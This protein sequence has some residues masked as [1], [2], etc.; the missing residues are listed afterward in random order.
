MV[1]LKLMLVLA[2]I[3]QGFTTFAQSEENTSSTTVTNDEVSE[4][5]EETPSPSGVEK[6]EVTGSHI[7]RTDVE[8]PSPVLVIDRQQIEASGFNSVSTILQRSTVSP[9]G[10][11]G[12]SVNLKGIG[13]G[14]TLI[15]INGQRAP[16]S[17]SSYASGAVSVDLVPL[18]A[19]E[20]IEVLKDGASATYGSDALG[21]VVN[22]ITRKN[23]DGFTFAN[24]YNM[25]T[26]IGTDM[27]RLSG[28]YG[29]QTSK[30]NF[31]TSM[32]MTWSQG[33]R[34]S[35]LDFARDL[36]KSFPFSTNYLDDSSA[37]RPGP[38]CNQLNSQGRCEEVVS[39]NQITEDGYGVDWVTQYSYEISSD[40][41]V[42]TSL[43][44][45]YGYGKSSFPNLLNTPGQF[46]GFDLTAA[47][48][49][50]AWNTL[51]GYTGGDTRIWHRFDDYVNTSIDQSYYAGLVTGVKG[52]LGNTDWQWDVSLNNQFNVATTK[53]QQL[54][55][56]GGA[57]D[58]IIGG[59]Y[60]PF[61]L[62]VRDTTGLGID[63]FNRNRAQISWL[64]AKTNGQLGSFLGIDW[65]A[66]FGV[67]GAHFEYADHRAD[68]ILNGEVMLQSGTAGRGERQLY[69]VFTEFSGLI[70]RNLELQFSLRGDMYSDFGET[71]NPKIAARYQA[72]KWLTF[73]TSAGTGFQAPT[74]QNM[75]ARIEGYDFLVDQVRCKDPSL[76]ND[77]PSAPDCQTQSISVFQN[78]NPN[79]KEETSLSLNFGTIIQP[80]ENLNFGFDFWYVKVEDTIGA[81]L[82][83]VLRLE[84]QYGPA[85][86]AGYG[87]NIIRTGGAP[88]GRI[89]RIAYT[90]FN[91]GEEQADG[92]DFDASYRL[93]TKAG[94]WMFSN[95]FSYM[96]HYHQSFYQE[97]G[98]EQVL[99]R[100]GLP[101]W[102][103]NFTLGYALGKWRAQAVVR[104]V[105]DMEKRVRGIGKVVSPSQY[106]A[107]VTYNPD[108]AGEFQIGAINI[109]NIRPR[110]DDSYSSKVNGALFRRTE[111]YY[112]TYRQDF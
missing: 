33:S 47:E 57:R 11:S 24:Q 18:A 6:I 73:R 25:S 91:V 109:G 62:S 110:F 83:D 7:R 79:L 72:A 104:S 19:V 20:R 5:Q 102:R 89:E 76:G 42:Y 15:L 60:D 31:M 64:E 98:K 111:T 45:G 10:G 49:P 36:N 1:L 34:S 82:D 8:G 84:Q 81:A 38:N 95:E 105:A 46:I 16:G 51:P 4:Q 35:H 50:A 3:L 66:A 75:N 41:E 23:I 61:D 97:F 54:A 63:A 103:N 74:L 69:S 44:A 94:D 90:L 9:F 53:E 32:Q 26:D 70:G 37:I 99:G 106:D 96:F 40:T 100:F 88:T 2:F 87:V 29:K 27:N 21:G 22:I 68:A 71:L 93:K 28:A 101:R 58:A 30:S 85:A 55:T 67:N 12:S 92:V 14:R 86:P 65:A 107:S 77:N 56:V 52:Y 43:I 59:T 13:S 17:G 80:T 108:W 48:T 112:L 39:V 78:T